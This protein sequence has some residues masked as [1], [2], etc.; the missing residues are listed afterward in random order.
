MNSDESSN[1]EDIDKIERNLDD[2]FIPEFVS[3]WEDDNDGV[4]EESKPQGTSY[5]TKF[6]KF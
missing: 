3:G 1:E 2:K 5:F 6:S 4:E